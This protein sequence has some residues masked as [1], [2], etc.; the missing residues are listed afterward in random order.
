MKKIILNLTVIVVL[1]T[2]IA[3][4]NGQA[5]DEITAATEFDVMKSDKDVAAANKNLLKAQSNFVLEYQKF[6]KSAEIKIGANEISIAD[7]KSE[8]MQMHVKDH[9]ARYQ[10]E[11]SGL[12]HKNKKLRKAL[13]NYINEGPEEWTSFKSM[14][15]RDMDELIKALKNFTIIDKK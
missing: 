14:F 9:S 2:T 6:R 13:T 10:K 12:D 11:I 4:I 8:I 7:V 1:A 3:T 5:P 15:N